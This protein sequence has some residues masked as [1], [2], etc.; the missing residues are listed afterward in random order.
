MLESDMT[1]TLALMLGSTMLSTMPVFAK[2]DEGKAGAT[3]VSAGVNHQAAF[4]HLGEML[5]E[6]IQEFVEDYLDK[7]DEVELGPLELYLKL[8]EEDYDFSQLPVVNST[9]GNNPHKFKY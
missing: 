7:K 2:P 8:V 3:P 5:P 1:R 9:K 6:V 4:Q